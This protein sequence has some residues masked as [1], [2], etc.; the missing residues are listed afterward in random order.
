MLELSKTENGGGYRVLNSLVA[1][2]LA[3]GVFFSNAIDCKVSDSMLAFNGWGESIENA[4]P[5]AQLVLKGHDRSG[6]VLVQ[7]MRP[8]VVENSS[9]ICGPETYAVGSL[10]TRTTADDLAT[11]REGLRIK[12][13]QFAGDK[14]RF[15][16]TAPEKFVSLSALEATG[17][18]PGFRSWMSLRK[19]CIRCRV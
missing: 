17:E 7:D 6:T 8:L 18:V 4:R 10:Y 15:F 5:A 11:L 2:N 13:V 14:E 19:V 12:G 16:L 3:G 1:Q 9:L